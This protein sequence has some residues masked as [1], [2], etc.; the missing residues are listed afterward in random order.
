M[1]VQKLGGAY[2]RQCEGCTLNYRI[3][4]GL[5]AHGGGS[6]LNQET[7]A[8]C[9]EASPYSVAMRPVDIRIEFTMP[10]ACL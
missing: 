1:M 4:W 7:L 6:T 10:V 9:F 8:A 3:F 2:P 5:Q